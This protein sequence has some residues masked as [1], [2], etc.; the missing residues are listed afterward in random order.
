MNETPRQLSETEQRLP[1]V[2]K[3]VTETIEGKQ[4]QKQIYADGSY[5]IRDR[6]NVTRYFPDG[7][8]QTYEKYYDLFI[9]SREVLPDGTYH[10]WHGNGQMSSEKLPNGT[11]HSW[12]NDGQ[13][14][15][16]K[17]PGGTEREWYDNGQVQKEK[18]PDGT[19]YVYYENGQMASEKLSDGAEY[20][21][22]ENGNLKDAHFPDGTMIR[23]DEEGNVTYHATKGVED[24][25]VYLAKQRVALKR[26]AKEDKLSQG[27][28][29]R[30]ILPKMN[31]LSKAIEMTKA[32]AIEMVNVKRRVNRHHSL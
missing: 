25:V 20:V 23:G 19:E 1:Q 4:V 9:L 13:M 18:L 12:Y 26:M 6:N 16:E 24:T 28:D 11:Y 32:K 29:E 3:I 17:L 30:V 5:V 15:K 27:K 31:K 2:E 21:Y 7:K 8:R 14:K 10:S 22:Y